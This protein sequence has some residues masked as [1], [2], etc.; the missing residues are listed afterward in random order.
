MNANR[1]RTLGWIA[2]GLWASLPALLLAKPAPFRL[3]PAVAVEAEDF[4]IEKGWKVVFNGQGNYM[5]DIIGFNHISGERLLCADKADTTA[6]AHADVDIPADGDYR[7]W[8]RYEYPTFSDARFRVTLAQG[9]R[10]SSSSDARA[11]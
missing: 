6:S 3:A 4:R 8:V 5:V 11:S 7:L 1:L 10:V 9:A 2:L